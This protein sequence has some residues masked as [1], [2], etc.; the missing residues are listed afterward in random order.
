MSVFSTF[1][2]LI[3]VFIVLDFCNLMELFINRENALQVKQ[4]QVLYKTSCNLQDITSTT[5][6]DA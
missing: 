4:C 2:A 1:M 5:N 6:T 3:F